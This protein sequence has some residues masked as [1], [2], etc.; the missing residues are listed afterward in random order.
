MPTAIHTVNPDDPYDVRY[1]PAPVSP[2]AAILA[3]CLPP[4]PRPGSLSARIAY[5]Q[6]S[7]GITYSRLVPGA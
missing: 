4:A 2:G 6:S 3:F 5:H 7:A 1:L